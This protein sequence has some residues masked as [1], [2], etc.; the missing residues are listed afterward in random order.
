M[1]LYTHTCS[2]YKHTCID[3]DCCG[4]YR[5]QQK[6]EHCNNLYL[7]AILKAFISD[8]ESDFSCPCTCMHPTL[9]RAGAAG[10]AGMVLAVPLFSHLTISRRELYSRGGVAPTWWHS[11]DVN[12]VHACSL[13]RPA[14]HVSLS[15]NFLTSCLLDSFFYSK[16]SV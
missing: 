4:E 12:V 5:Q 15:W 8:N 6:R 10:T 3:M 11:I 16:P 13:K 9:L 14:A 2:R 7:V 1:V